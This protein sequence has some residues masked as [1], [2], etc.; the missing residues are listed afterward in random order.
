M[1]FHSRKCIWKWRLRNVGHFVSASMCWVNKIKQIVPFSHTTHLKSDVYLYPRNEVRGG[2]VNWIHPVCFC[3]SV[4]PSV[5]L[6]LCLSV[7]L[8]CPPCSS[9]SSGW[10]LSIFGTNDQKHKRVCRMWW[11]LTYI[12]KVIRHWLRKSCPLCSVYSSG[13]IIFIF[14]TNDHYY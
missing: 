13:W 10:I 11:P 3:P 2:G 7:N 14:C 8:S 6:I 1:H 9:Y 12:F 4:C 5:R